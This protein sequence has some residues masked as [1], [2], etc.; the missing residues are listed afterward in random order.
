VPAAGPFR[1]RADHLLVV[2]KVRAAVLFAILH[3]IVLMRDHKQVGREASL[4]AG[5]LDSQTIKARHAAS[6]GSFDAAKHIKGRKRHIATDTGGRLL[7]FNLIATDVQDA[8]EAEKIVKAVGKHWSR[9]NYLFADGA[10]DRG[11]VMSA[12]A[13]RD[14]VIEMRASRQGRLASMFCHAAGR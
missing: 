14:F 11:K 7:M 1:D 9:L 3:N 5:V 2:P 8:D 13:Y 6:A 12:A 4:I 10:Y